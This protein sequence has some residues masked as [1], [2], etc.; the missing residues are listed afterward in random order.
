MPR[1]GSS[2]DRGYGHAHRK[3]TAELKQQMT[4]GQPCA[5]CGK[6]MWRSQLNQIHGDHVGRARVLGGIL[7]DALSH[8]RC[9]TSHGA[10]LGNRLRGARRRVTGTTRRAL[11]QW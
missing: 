7:P 1:P 11:P 3:R 5:R 9:N 2:T 6:P 4:D 10:K 8:A